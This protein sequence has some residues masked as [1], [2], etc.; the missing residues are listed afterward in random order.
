[1]REWINVLRIR[2]TVEYPTIVIVGNKYDGNVTT[3]ESK[4]KP[5]EIEELKEKEKG[6]IFFNI[7]ARTGLNMTE[8]MEAMC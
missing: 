3:T 5:Q 4:V 7:S 6:I 1:V 2:C 8:V